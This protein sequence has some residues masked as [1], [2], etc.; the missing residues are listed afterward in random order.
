MK[1]IDLPEDILLEITS[2]LSVK[3]VLLLKQTCR[4]LH[5]FG[6][7]D[8]L[9]H[10][11]V[12]A[13]EFPLDTLQN[14]RSTDF[15]SD[16]LQRSAIKALRL[17]ANWRKPSPRIR[18]TTALIT[19]TSGSYVDEMHI[20]PGGRWL[21]TSQ[22]L[23]QR[24]GRWT[25]LMTLWSLE[26]IQHARRIAHVEITGAQRTPAAFALQDGGDS[27]LLA[28]GVHDD[29]DFIEVHN[30]SI[31][32]RINMSYSMR[33]AR[34]RVLPLPPYS[35][36]VI[37]HVLQE[38]S[39]FEDLIAATVVSLELESDDRPL[40][41]LLSDAR[42]GASAWVHPR[43]SEPFSFLWVRLRDGYI[44]LTGRLGAAV[45]LR[46]YKL[47]QNVMDSATRSTR[48]MGDKRSSE[49]AFVDLGDAV[50]EFLSS[51]S[52]GMH[53]V[54]QV[55]SA[56]STGLALI[57]F[58]SFNGMERATGHI[59]RFRFARSY[60]SIKMLETQMQCL[61]LQQEA[62]AQLADIGATGRRA[63]WLEHNWETQQK[64]LMRFEAQDECEPLG[65]L[66]PPDPGLPFAPHACHS[67]AFDE[68][69]GRLCLGFFNGDLYVVDFV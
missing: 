43:Y 35:G 2:Y 8:Y 28:V 47:P 13:F 50:A 36:T 40:R 48:A 19:G 59:M 45:V 15:S 34:S 64:R 30:I 38:L 32:D 22:R 67:L 6:S 56:S 55:S 31:E 65:V 41:I 20:L 5:A 54:A 52:A 62:S 14:T 61:Q 27:V 42:S 57:I 53:D 68:V 51:T 17:D 7:S 69:T 3:D 66:L 29:T 10:R 4:A 1:L 21:L 24:E 58:H 26:D 63:V 18:R 44:F 9:W 11:L 23:R 16:E 12:A 33:P 37:R 49:D 39:M 60:D 46:I 25:S